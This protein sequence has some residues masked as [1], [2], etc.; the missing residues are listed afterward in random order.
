MDLA[1]DAAFSASDAMSLEISLGDSDVPSDRRRAC[2]PGSR[3]PQRHLTIT[4]HRL[5]WPIAA[6]GQQASQTHAICLHQ[7]N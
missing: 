7:R 3:Q 2:N 1:R 6:S 4:H 5:L